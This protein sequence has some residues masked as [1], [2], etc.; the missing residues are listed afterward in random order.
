M[1]VLLLSRDRSRKNYRDNRSLRQQHENRERYRRVRGLW[2]GLCAV[3]LVG[4]SSPAHAV[5]DIPNLAVVVAPDAENSFKP[6]VALQETYYQNLYQVPAGAF[7]LSTLV[8]PGQ[9]RDDYLSTATAGADGTWTAARQVVAF[10]AR[11]DD[12]RFDH[13]TDLDNVS[14]LGKVQLNWQASDLLSGQA[15]YFYTRTLAAF[16]DTR[17]FASDSVATNQIFGTF[18]YQLGPHWAT[19]GTAL[20]THTT[21]SAPPERINDA[22]TNVYTAG[23]E[24]AT[25]IK[26]TISWEYDRTEGRYPSD[27]ELQGVLASRN[28]VENDIRLLTTYN[29][30][31]KTSLVANLGYLKRTYA[32]ADVGAFSGDTWRV[33]LQWAAT[34][35][36]QFSIAA[37]HE[38]QAFLDSQSDY[39][40]GKGASLAPVWTIS[41]KLALSALVTYAA[42]DYINSSLNVLTVGERRDTVAQQQL[43]L[44][45]KATRALTLKF[46]YE[47]DKRD[48]N[49][50][51]FSYDGSV[52]SLGA[53]FTF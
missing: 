30:T 19:Y 33:T 7:Y 24:Y 40:I 11:V 1:Y 18:R 16:A 51:I 27:V 6:F 3:A 47:Y 14:G 20:E 9:S 36:L 23:I 38:L 25:S 50:P 48:S 46:S 34:A 21:N 53:R 2:A 42:Q 44:N 37:W 10:T 35:K 32:S 5:P 12:N 52:V 29:F 8:G 22:E 41:D 31:D 39:F 49:Q 45:Y 26:N 43:S 15:G 13:N 17:Y 28:Y 4:L